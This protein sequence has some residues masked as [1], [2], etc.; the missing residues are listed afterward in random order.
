VLFNVIYYTI[1]RFNF[2]VFYLPENK[3][4]VAL[5][6]RVTRNKNNSILISALGSYFDLPNFRLLD[7]KSENLNVYSFK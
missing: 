1:N 2:I 6:S 3:L 7:L 4:A 5:T